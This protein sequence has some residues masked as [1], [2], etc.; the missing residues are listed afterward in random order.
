MINIFEHPNNLDYMLNFV[1]GHKVEQEDYLCITCYDELKIAFNF[2][3]KCQQS[4]LYRSSSNKTFEVFGS[5]VAATLGD[6]GG[7]SF[8]IPTSSG[9]RT[10]YELQYEGNE[11]KISTTIPDEENQET[12]ED[13][14][15]DQKL[16]DDNDDFEELVEAGK[17][18]QSIDVD[19]ENYSMIQSIAASDENEEEVDDQPFDELD[20]QTEIKC[21]L[22]DKTFTK[23]GNFHRHMAQIHSIN[24]KSERMPRDKHRRGPVPK[25]PDDDIYKNLGERQCEYCFVTLATIEL[26]HEHESQHKEEERPYRCNQ[27]NCTARFKD[28]YS[29][30]SHVRIHSDQKRYKCRFC[31]QGFH[32]RGNLKAHERCHTGEKPFVCP[33]CGKAFAE[34]GNLKSH[35]RFHTG[36]RPYSCDYCSKKFRTHYSH[37]IHVR[38]HT[39]ERPFECDDCGKSFNCSGKL[40]IHKRIHTGH[41][42]Y[43][44]DCGASF[45]DSSRL[46]RH[47]KTHSE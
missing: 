1:T 4:R 6:I 24:M 44:C 38:S 5:E 23:K 16:D 28:R 34:N 10:K 17:G 45:I 40:R 2:K 27:P 31:S 3:Q 11:E 19:D 37:K 25:Y 18:L 21:D 22:C 14:L 43:K 47:S 41:R 8:E 39:Q 36:E 15:L 7:T 13:Y 30:R 20:D 12:S 9:T 33:H 32:Q 29:V 26:L 35:I 46:K 42:P